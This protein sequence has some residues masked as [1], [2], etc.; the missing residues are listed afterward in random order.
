M[1][2]VI[3]LDRKQGAV[4]RDPSSTLQ[5]L[6]VEHAVNHWRNLPAD[7]QSHTVLVLDGGQIFQ[8]TEIE[9]I[10]FGPP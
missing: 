3:D 9:L 4:L 2:R 5:F 10:R 1:E 7:Q 6:N 8:P